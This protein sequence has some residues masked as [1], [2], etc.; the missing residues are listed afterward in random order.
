MASFVSSYFKFQQFSVSNVKLQALQREVSQFISPCIQFVYML[1]SQKE[2]ILK[3]N[4]LLI[5][6]NYLNITELCDFGNGI[7]L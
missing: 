6:R 4:D 1:R 7:D 2:I 3:S 5:K